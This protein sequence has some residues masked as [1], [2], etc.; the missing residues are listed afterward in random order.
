MSIIGVSVLNYVDYEA[1]LKCLASFARC[2]PLPDYIVVVDNA[3]PNQSWERLTEECKNLKNTR[4]IRAPRNGGFSYGHNIGIRYLRDRGVDHVILATSDTEVVSTEIIR[5]FGAE[6]TETVGIIGPTIYVP[7][8]SEQNPSVWQLDMRYWAALAWFMWGRPGRSLWT[9]IRGH[10]P[11]KR[12]LVSGEPSTDSLTVYKLHGAF[13]MLTRAFLNRYPQLDEDLFMF[14]EE[15]LL[16]WRSREAGL[17]LRFVPR[18]RIRHQ[19]DS[20]INA[21]QADQATS[22][23][24]E[25]EA[26]AAKVLKTKIPLWRLLYSAVTEQL[27]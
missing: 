18:V 8:G 27:R 14:G 23:V 6:A 22:F 12:A 25:Q 9:S 16:A 4:L 17:K 13:F 19:N 1:T 7:N 15:D 26:R 11:R 2:D 3:S 24:A 10:F 21:S 20:S 5:V